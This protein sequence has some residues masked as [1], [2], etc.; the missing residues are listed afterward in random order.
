MEAKKNAEK[1]KEED[2]E[3]EVPEIVVPPEG[4]IFCLEVRRNAGATGS[5]QKTA[6][7]AG[8]SGNDTADRMLIICKSDNSIRAGPTDPLFRDAL[9]E[10]HVPFSCKAER[11][12]VATDGF[13]GK[14]ATDLSGYENEDDEGIANAGKFNDAQQQSAYELET[15]LDTTVHVKGKGAVCAFLDICRQHFMRNNSQY[16]KALPNL[17]SPTPF[18]HS[19]FKKCEVSTF[20]RE[21][22]LEFPNVEESALVAAAGGGNN[23]PREKRLLNHAA[24]K[25]VLFPLQIRK[26]LQCFEIGNFT[27]HLGSDNGTSF[28]CDEGRGLMQRVVYEPATAQEDTCC[29]QTEDYIVNWERVD[30][31]DAEM[32][33]ANLGFNQS[34]NLQYLPK[35]GRK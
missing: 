28:L 26:L 8:G 7:L 10:H 31:G 1:L 30:K 18:L 19:M 15:S 22:E 17:Y 32:M 34:R 2:P 24:I 9:K 35:F 25:G 12:V 11:E 16:N 27:V 21:E 4:E 23:P 33:H 14:M 20:Q 13:A 6:T 5:D 29:P 3:A